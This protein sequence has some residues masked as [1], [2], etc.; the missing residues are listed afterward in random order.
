MGVW[1]GV[2]GG[3]G[4]MIKAGADVC[5]VREAEDGRWR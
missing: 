3:T 4:V 5:G 2:G 1:V